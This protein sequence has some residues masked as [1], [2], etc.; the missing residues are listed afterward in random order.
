MRHR[1]FAH[2]T[3]TT[4]D[5]ARM[6][7]AEA[8]ALLTEMLRRIAGEERTELLAVGIV[9][10]HI[11]ALIRFRPTTELPRLLQR[12]KGST[13]ALLHRDHGIR[14][15][16]AEGYNIETL[17]S[18]SLGAV[19]AYVEQQ[20]QHHPDEAIHGWDPEPTGDPHERMEAYL[21]TLHSV[22]RDERAGVW[23]RRRSRMC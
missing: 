10:T 7:D 15:R 12:L 21:R 20:A 14:I 18:R 11:H 9:S 6:V 17:S 3:W 16:W 5:R 8:A 4:R 19:A 1:C 22:E 13:A 23:R 2:L